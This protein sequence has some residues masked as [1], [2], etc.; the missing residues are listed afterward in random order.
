M[1][2]NDAIGDHPYISERLFAAQVADVLRK[3]CPTIKGNLFR[4]FFKANALKNYTLR[5]GYTSDEI[6]AYLKSDKTKAFYLSAAEEYLRA[7]GVEEGREQ[8]YCA[9]AEQEID[10]G[11]TAG[12][13]L[14]S[15]K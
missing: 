11:T 9:V 15:T 7:Q 8:S 1:R 13:L 5:L 4:F 12:K 6:R 2:A 3:K 14:R 10:N